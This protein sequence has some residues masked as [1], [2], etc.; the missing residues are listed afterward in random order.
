MYKLLYYIFILCSISIYGIEGLNIK[1]NENEKE[2]IKKNKDINMTIYLDKDRGILNYH[3]KGQKKGVFPNIIK[4]LEKETG[5]KFHIIDEETEKFENSVDLG[6]PDIVVGV[7]DY[8][9]N[10]KKYY[11]IDQPIELDGV[12][13][14]KSEFPSIDFKDDILGKTVVYEKGDQ[15]KNKIVKKYGRSVK[16][17]PKAN[18]KECI[19]ALLSGEADIYIDDYQDTLKYL[20]DNN[21]DRIKL[22]YLSRALKTDY[23]IGGKTKFEP[24]IDIIEKILDNKKLTM[25]FFH[26]ESLSYTKNKLEITDQI[27]EYISSKNEIKILMPLFEEFPQLYYS[28]KNNKSEGFLKDYFVEV[29]KIL[30]INIKFKRQNLNSDFDINPFIL[31]INGNELISKTE[32]ILI[33]EPYTQIPLLIFNKSDKGYIPYFDN[34]KKYRIA[35]V[36]NSFIEEYL[37]YK[38][39]GNNLVRFKNIK[40]VLMAVSSKEADIL[41]GDLQQINYY[42]NLFHINDLK[43][44]GT[45]QDKVELSFGVP[46]EEKTLYFLINSLN[47]KFSYRIKEEKSK[48]FLQ[49]VELAKD[50]KLSIVI[51]IISIVLISFIYSHLRRFKRVSNK[52]KKLTI[53]LVETLEN[54][55]TFNDEDTGSH[56]KRISKYSEVLAKELRLRPMC[57]DRIS[58]YASLH[59]VGKIGIPDNILKKP[60]KLTVEEFEIMKNHVEIG[61]NLMKDLDISSVALNIVRYHHEKWNGTG[62]GKGLKEGEIPIEAR[63]VAIADVYDALRQKRVYKEA[64]SHEKSVEIIKSESGKHFDPNLV[65]IF[66]KK[67]QNFN[68]IFEGNEKEVDS[69]E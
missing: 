45:I 55:N 17:L 42:S 30:G 39:F 46:I 66:I 12:M 37:L 53:G 54:A 23:Y 25:K 64:F 9:R 3:S 4:I 40:E 31:S 44:A 18:Q 49:K 62:Y 14:T 50:Y 51:F 63:I 52:L 2:W 56:I 48:F 36:D 60:G 1:L 38:G 34:L 26:E 59:D 10:N 5:L 24:L 35:V 28:D 8:K 47:N 65:R 69:Y 33:T 6:I 27:S 16:L 15:I 32:K 67:Q 19:E 58:L 11:Y 22:N 57:I 7:E 61:Y 20:I 41:I 43:V 29:G 21:D 68:K 13:V